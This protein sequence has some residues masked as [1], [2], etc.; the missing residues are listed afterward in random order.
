M[1]AYVTPPNLTTLFARVSTFLSGSPDITWPEGY[2]TLS[3][4]QSSVDD[5][6]S[7]DYKLLDPGL[8]PPYTK[9]ALTYPTAPTDDLMAAVCRFYV[10]GGQQQPVALPQ[11]LMEWVPNPVNVWVA[12]GTLDIELT[13]GLAPVKE[14]LNAN[15]TV[16]KDYFN[17]FYGGQDPYPAL[18]GTVSLGMAQ[19][20]TIP[21]Y[22]F[23]SSNTALGYLDNALVRSS[24]LGYVAE[25]TKTGSTFNVD[26]VWSDYAVGRNS[27]N[28]LQLIDLDT[29]AVKF[30][31]PSTILNVFGYFNKLWC[32]C[33]SGIF[34][35]TG[36]ANTLNSVAVTSTGNFDNTHVISDTNRNVSIWEN[37]DYHVKA[38]V[39]SGRT[40][41]HLMS[42]GGTAYL[43]NSS[44]LV[45]YLTDLATGLDVT[46]KAFAGGVTAKSIKDYG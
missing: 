14:T 33:T 18:Q 7:S 34:A 6:T 45:V 13:S 29:T 21:V 17:S 10:Q 16:T 5:T 39:P 4:P 2:S 23:T 32:I 28:K 1:K 9:L 15:L 41:L 8:E 20:N 35:A 12:D 37:G 22:T 38:T 24:G 42:V 19:L 36:T 40:A 30:T 26:L 31:A 27:A 11:T 46:T 43:L 44:G 25:L 3:L